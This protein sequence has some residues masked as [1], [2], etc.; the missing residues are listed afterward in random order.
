MR[1][2]ETC[3]YLNTETNE[4]DHTNTYKDERLDSMLDG[5]G[6]IAMGSL[7]LFLT[8]RRYRSDRR[9]LA[10]KHL[11]PP[12]SFPPPPPPPPPLPPP[13]P[14]PPAL[15]HDAEPFA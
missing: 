7:I 15:H 1:G 8:S 13:P 2:D 6:A 9:K 14:A 10:H 12:P 5:L 3:V 11:P 4:I